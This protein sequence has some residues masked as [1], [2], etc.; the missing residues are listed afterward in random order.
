MAPPQK[1]RG[2]SRHNERKGQKPNDIDQGKTN[3]TDAGQGERPPKSGEPMSFPTEA[4]FPTDTLL[5]KDSLAGK[6]AR[7]RQKRPQQVRGPD[8]ER[9]S[10]VQG[11]SVS[12]RV[13]LGGRRYIKKKRHI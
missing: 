1:H 4:L 9:T 11:K 6:V 2:R 3:Y 7:Q 13:D 8:Q 12:V 10:A 5:A